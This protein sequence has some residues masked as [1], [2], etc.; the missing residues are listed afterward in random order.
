MDPISGDVNISNELKRISSELMMLVSRVNA[1]ALH[2]DIASYTSPTPP[3][4][5]KKGRKTPSNHH[6]K[7]T[8]QDKERLSEMIKDKNSRKEMARELQRTTHA[9]L[10]RQRQIA[11]QK[12]NDGCSR[13]EVLASSGLTLEELDRGD[14]PR[15]KRRSRPVNEVIMVVP[16]CTS[17]E[18]EPTRPK[19]E[20]QPSLVP[21]PDQVGIVE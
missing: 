3:K 17:P 18:W 1:L 15:G 5:Q 14:F 10:C 6:K 9:V 13:E 2:L 8:N 7:W 19:E 12:Q 16:G 4:G 20:L 11:L 21:G